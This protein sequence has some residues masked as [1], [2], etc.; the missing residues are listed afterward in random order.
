M[1]D[2]KFRIW[3]YN[4]KQFVNPYY[5]AIK[6]NVSGENS[7]I[8]ESAHLFAPF[9]ERNIDSFEIQQYTGQKDKIGREIYEGDIVILDGEPGTYEIKWDEEAVAFMV[10]EDYWSD[11]KTIIIGNIYQNPELLK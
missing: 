5:F 11:A 2:L 3:N 6:C 10:G 1:K 9:L 7:Q 4:I 8:L